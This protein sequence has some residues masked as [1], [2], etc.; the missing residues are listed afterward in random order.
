MVLSLRRSGTPSLRT[1]SPPGIYKWDQDV[2]RKV[3]K[4]KGK[5]AG[6]FAGW[7]IVMRI[8]KAIAAALS[9]PSPP[10]IM[11]RARI[12]TNPNFL[13]MATNIYAH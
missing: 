12:H 4:L 2:V 3:S 11:I 5:A 6:A 7:G 13:T 8:V 1:S 9:S 10:P